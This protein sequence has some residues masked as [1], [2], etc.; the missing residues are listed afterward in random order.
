MKVDVIVPIYYINEHFKENVKSWYKAIPI[1]R[2]FIGIGDRNA[3][4]KKMR[5]ILF[6]FKPEIIGIYFQF[7]HTTLG[8]C[9]KELIDK[10]ETAW[11][12]YLHDDVK[13][14]PEWFEE[15]SKY[16]GEADV[17][18]SLKYPTC[19]GYINQANSDRAYSGA[20]LMNTKIIK[21][22]V[23]DWEDDFIYTIEDIIIYHRLRLNGY[24]YKKV[25]VYHE[26]QGHEIERTQTRKT[27]IW[28]QIEALVKYLPKDEYTINFFY[29][30]F[31]ELTKEYEK[32]WKKIGE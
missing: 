23:S 21:E 18:E 10:V 15:I 27:M 7:Q 25:P 8:Y 22:M 30:P 32:E 16:I 24:T 5:D 29:G 20:Q 1:R 19:E 6:Q 17:I 9:M 26:H 3:D 13:L 2:L 4:V 28:W 12:V 31:N 14:P 11:F